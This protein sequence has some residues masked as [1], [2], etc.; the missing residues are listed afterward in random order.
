MKNTEIKQILKEGK[1]TSLASDS[2][3]EGWSGE[4][5]LIRHKGGKYALRKCKKIDRAKHYV[6][7]SKKLEKYGFLPKLL[8]RKGKNVVYEYIEGRDLMRKESI[9]VIKQ[10]GAIAAYINKIKTKGP[11]HERFNKQLKE[12]ITGKFTGI[13]KR[14]KSLLSK[15]KISKIKKLHS[16]L[17]KKTKTELRED[18]NDTHPDNF[19][20]RKGK[21]YFVDIEAIKPRIIL[22]GLGKAFIKW[23]KKPK[24]R[25]YFKK[26]YASVSSIKFL[27]KKYEDLIYLNYLIQE[28]NYREKLGSKYKPKFKMRL[29]ALDLLLKKYKHIL[30]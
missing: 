9:N 23:F 2:K 29:E 13:K 10:I 15:E 17:R 22:Y 6:K 26:G 16:Y 21:V 24:Q 18:I 3:I 5:H 30:K 11:V 7:I 28:V 20:L 19:R 1:I 27:T 4:A 14:K 25:E 8:G 12:I